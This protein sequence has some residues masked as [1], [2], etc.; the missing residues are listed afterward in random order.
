LRATLHFEVDSLRDVLCIRHEEL[1]QGMDRNGWMRIDVPMPD[2]VADGE[3][4]QS[5]QRIRRIDEPMASHGG[6]DPRVTDVDLERMLSIHPNCRDFVDYRQPRALVGMLRCH[7]EPSERLPS[8]MFKHRP[9]GVRVDGD[10]LG[11][12]ADCSLQNP[13]PL[14][15]PEEYIDGQT[16]VTKQRVQRR[17]LE[18][19]HEGWIRQDGQLEGRIGEHLRGLRTRE[20]REKW[21][22][23]R[24]IS[25]E[26]AVD[27][28]VGDPKQE[29]CNRRRDAGVGGH[30]PGSCA[31]TGREHLKYL[32]RGVP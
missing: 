23:R 13:H 24:G 15:T 8:D 28:Y 31:I 17:G 25:C 5:H 27:A 1:L 22:G 2:G 11:D 9:R 14:C 26:C 29:V 10:Q 16:G 3:H 18:V 32:G 6:D 30:K 12:S 7:M 21:R 20:L 19:Q 4:E